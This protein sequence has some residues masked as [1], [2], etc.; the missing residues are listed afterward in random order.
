[1]KRHGPPNGPPKTARPDF[2]PPGQGRQQVLPPAREGAVIVNLGGPAGM[3]DPSAG[4]FIDGRKVPNVARVTV[5]ADVATGVRTVELT[6]HAGDHL[7]VVG[8]ASVRATAA[9]G[10]RDDAADPDP[11]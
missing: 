9:P 8:Y 5:E 3:L 4:V 10:G 6:I 11:G 1:M 7:S 2:E